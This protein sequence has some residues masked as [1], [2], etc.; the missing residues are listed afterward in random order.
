[1]SIE[2]LITGLCVYIAWSFINERACRN[3][4]FLNPTEMY[5]SYNDTVL[6]NRTVEPIKDSLRDRQIV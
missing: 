4:P 5:L 2:Q 1:M 3:K 6:Y